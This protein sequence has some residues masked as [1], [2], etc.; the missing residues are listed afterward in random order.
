MFFI[1]LY[2]FGFFYVEWNFFESGYGKGILDVV[3][4]SFKWKV[5]FK[6]KFGCDIIFVKIFVDLVVGGKIDVSVVG[7]LEI[8]EY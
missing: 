1:E 2:K 8:I 7:E 5:D 6:V 3:G 4:G